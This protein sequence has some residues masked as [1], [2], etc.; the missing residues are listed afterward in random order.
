[1]IYLSAQPDHIYFTWQLEVQFLNFQEL[2]I[3]LSSYHVLVGIKGDLPSPHFS[4]LAK[5]YPEVKWQFI[6]DTRIS[7][8]YIPSIRPHI[9]SKYFKTNLELENEDIFYFDSDVIFRETLDFTKL[10]QGGINYVS[11]TNSYLNTRY[12]REKGGDE[13]LQAMCNIIGVTVEQIDGLEKNHGGAQYFLQKGITYSFWEK[14]ESDCTKLYCYLLDNTHLYAKSWSEK[15]G[16]KIEEY[17]EIQAWCSDM[18]CVL[19]NLVLL[20]RRVEVTDE[21][22]FSWATGT[23]EQYEGCKIFHNAGV[24][25]ETSNKFFF[26]GRYIQ[27][28]P[29]DLD[30]SFISK[31]SASYYYS[32]YVNKLVSQRK[33]S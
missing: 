26:K 8:R 28:L 19:W 16:K 3:P 6:K 1:M 11:D 32:I 27:G 22:N 18:W 17:H 12:I 15:T 25:E 2:N 21:L 10:K 13:M 5:K 14:I 33:I 4:S 20:G 9:I 29:S 7:K 24:T 30:L 31:E 23:K